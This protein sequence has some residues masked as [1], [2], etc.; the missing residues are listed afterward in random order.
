MIKLILAVAMGVL[1][2][3]P[4]GSC[5][6]LEG[7]L[8]AKAHGVVGDGTSDD[9][10]AIQ[11]ALDTAAETGGTVYFPPGKYLLK[12]HLNIPQ[13]VSIRGSA[14]APRYSEPL[15]GTV[16]LATE[17]RSDESAP[18]LIKLN[19]SSAVT[20]LTIYYPDQ[21]CE[22][23]KPYPWTFHLIN[24]DN[25]LENLTLVNSYN[26][27]RVGP[28]GNV[29]HRIKSVYGCVLRRGLF[30]DSCYDIGRV[31]N[32]QFHGHWWWLKE[33]HGDEDTVNNYMIENL[34]AFIFGRTDWE[35][36]TNTFVYPAKI[37]YRFIET[38]TGACNG[39]FSGIGADYTQRAIVVDQ[40]QHM[41]LLITNGE[42]VSFAGDDPTMII[43]N[44]TCTGQ[45][46]LVNC[47]FW[48]PCVQNVVSR[49]KYFLSMSDCYFSTPTDQDKAIVEVHD[50]RLQIRGCSFVGPRPSVAIRDG[51]KHAIITGNNGEHG[52][53]V[54]NEIG[55]RAIIEQNEPPEEGWE[56]EQE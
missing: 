36:V 50:G 26:G 12:G 35:Y 21:R 49:G 22:D 39:Q 56:F 34:E 6:E 53:A 42:F 51:V 17:G 14:W 8:N 4:V 19:G 10:A 5:H 55:D 29:R 32:V 30:V 54:I 23:I 40:I 33:L 43:I 28:E 3:A 1:L 27:I 31:E 47:A 52:V 15:T 25:T 16:L 24:I 37:G 13:G 11:K 38:E 45:I 44:E 7:V 46:R 18:P 20:G 41:G 48:G 2:W 9:T